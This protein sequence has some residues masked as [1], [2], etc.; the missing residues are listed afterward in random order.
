FKRVAIPSN[1]STYL[2][3]TLIIITVATT[4]IIGG[5]LIIQQKFYFNNISEQKSKEYI[6]DQKIYIQEIVKNELEYIR[7]QN[8]AFKQRINSKIKSNV[9]QAIN[10]AESIYQ[11]YAGK[12]SDEEIK[13]LIITAVSSLKFN[14]EFEEVFISTMD[15]VG[16]YYPRNPEFT[17]KYLRKFK[18]VNGL[19]VIQE[20]INLLKNNA[21]GYLDYNINLELVPE[22]SPNKKITFVKKFSQYGWYFGSKQYVDDFFPEF[23]NEIAEKISSVRFRHGGYIF[24]N[25]VNGT[26]IVMDGKVY[27]GDLNLINTSDDMRSPVF[28]QQLD[29]AKNKPDGGFFYYKWNKINETTPS[30]KCSYAQLFKDYDWIVGAGFYMDEIENT[31]KEQEVSLRRDQQKSILIIVFILICLLVL[32]A[33]IIYHFNKR[34][35]ADFER[36]FNFFFLSQHSFNKLNISNFYFDEFKKAGEAANEMIVL[37][38][39]IQD[40]LIEE[41]QKAMESDR[42]KSA[43]LANMSH[44]IRTPMNAILGF[45]ELLED[46]SQDEADKTVFVSLIRKNGDILLNLINDIIDISKIEANLLS[47]RKRPVLLNKFLNEINEHYTET[48]ALKRDKKI[49][50]RMNTIEN[51][52]IS[53][54]TDESRLRQILDNL[55]GNAIKF[56]STGTVSLDVNIQGDRVHFSVTDTGIGIPVEQQASIFERFIQANEGHK[57]NFGGTGLGLAISKNLIVLLGGNIGVE[58]ELG[59][60]SKFYFSIQAN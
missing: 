13:V 58:S 18:D 8:I 53:I 48:L 12:K 59:K 25:H 45:S 17:G 22:T 52:T 43:F 40:R 30:D 11:R 36:F 14:M 55:I 51:Q 10:I 19:P 60:G 23:R 27:K 54:L 29:I 24:M 42:L 5:V 50:F 26:P 41:Q 38:K 16:V 3:H 39:E 56:T 20:E 35:K 34:Y 7:L 49:Q 32:E 47:V 6:A 28:L 31:I 2:S 4:L 21:E 37:R 9:Y 1:I 46:E 57:M 33:I 44:E 15:G